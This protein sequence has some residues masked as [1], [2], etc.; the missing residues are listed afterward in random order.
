MVRG[1]L[2]SR[3][4][5]RQPVEFK[6]KSLYYNDLI[7]NVAHK[8]KEAVQKLKFLK[9][10]NDHCSDFPVLYSGQSYWKCIHDKEVYNKIKKAKR[11]AAELPP[12]RSDRWQAI[13]CKKDCA[14]R[15]RLRSAAANGRAA[16]GSAAGFLYYTLFFRG[17]NFC[18]VDLVPLLFSLFL[19]Y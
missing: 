3:L 10:A 14:V 12:S 6:I 2:K 9:T 16:A 1:C 11:E 13:F 18:T 8:I 5:S 17:Y 15:F 7:L 4:L 19:L